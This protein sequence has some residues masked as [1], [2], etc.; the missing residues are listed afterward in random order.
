MAA[1]SKLKMHLDYSVS[2]TVLLTDCFEDLT[3]SFI[4]MHTFTNCLQ[5]INLTSRESCTKFSHHIQSQFESKL[6]D[7][8]LTKFKAGIK[9]CDICD[10]L[11]NSLDNFTAMLE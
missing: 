1:S 8:I 11:T 9:F 3:L 10:Y 4:L 6:L 2:D 5:A 7:Q